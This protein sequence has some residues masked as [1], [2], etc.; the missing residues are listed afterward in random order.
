M[1]NHGDMRKVCGFYTICLKTTFTK[2]T[3]V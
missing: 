1:S 3:A 2:F